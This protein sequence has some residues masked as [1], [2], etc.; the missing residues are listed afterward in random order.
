MA[1]ERLAA[2]IWDSRS[3]TA[4]HQSYVLFQEGILGNKPLTWNSL[5]EVKAS[6]WE[7]LICIRSRKGI[8]RSRTEFNKTYQESEQIVKTWVSEGMDS[9]NITFNQAMPDQ[10]LVLQGE[11]EHTIGGLYLYG[12]FV[13][14]PMNLGL[15]EKS[16][17]ISGFGAVS[18]LQKCLFP[19]SY[20]DLG[21]L[22][23]QFPSS[24]VEFSSYSRSVGN[25]RGRNT[26]FWE[27]R[28]Y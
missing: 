15:A 18:L 4:K 1:N 27:L 28:N 12:T 25:L 14:K 11:V 2:E 21:R 10:D 20:A 5:A 9:K 23:E 22:L 6:G 16:F 8:A 24:I 26:V 3:V 13:K 7:G 19:Q 17:S